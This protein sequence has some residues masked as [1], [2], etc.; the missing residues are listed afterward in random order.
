DAPGQ[1]R[2]RLS[3]SENASQL[4]LGHLIHHAPESATRGAWRG[5]GF[6]LRT[7]AWLALRAG[8]G[9]LLSTTARPNGQSTQMDV[10]EAVGQLKAAEETAKALSDAAEKQG[11]QPLKAN[12]EQSK[13]IKS[14]DPKQDGK[15]E[16]S[17]GGQPAKKATPG[18]RDPGDPTE[19]FAQAHIVLE[20]PSDISHSSP[21]STLLYAGQHLHLTS[22]QDLHIAA[23][24]THALAIGQS[25][26]WFSHAGGIKSVAQAGSHT[27][28]AH[29]DKLEIL[30][31]Q[32]ATLTSSNDEI[33]ILAKSKI[34][35]QA[36]QSSV[37]LEGSNITFACPGT[38][39]VKGSN[40]AFVGPGSGPAEREALPDSRVKLYDEAFILKDSDTG[41]PLANFPYRI[42]RPDGS[43]EVG[44]TDNNGHTHLVP[45][46][47]IEKLLIEVLK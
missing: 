3:T 27:L 47:D 44:I 39:S 1:L 7:D 2:T 11:A 23:A 12:A 16:G 36:G 24:H 14:I 22:Q 15:F 45:S 32:S 30:V 46:A 9:I 29:T 40:H 41:E 17:I 26:S 42:R 38:F 8:E 6:E 37:T 10:A 33:H 28:Q 18:S 4:S 20:A 43:Y 35:L 25:A 19:R 34:V 5:A 13:F 31:D 21:A